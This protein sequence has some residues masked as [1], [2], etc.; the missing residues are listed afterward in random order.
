[1]FMCVDFSVSFSNV[2]VLFCFVCFVR[3]CARVCV[4]VCVRLFAVFCCLFVLLCY[5]L[6]CVGL[7]CVGLCCFAI[8]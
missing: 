6:F 5:T 8:I 1:M 3:V 7:V 4:R 2:C